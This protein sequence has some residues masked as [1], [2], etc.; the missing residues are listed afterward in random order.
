METIELKAAQRVLGERTADGKLLSAAELVRMAEQKLDQSGLGNLL[1]KIPEQYVWEW[2]DPTVSELRRFVERDVGKYLVNA[3]RD[4][5]MALG[6][7]GPLNDCP[8]IPNWLNRTKKLV[9]IPKEIEEKLLRID[10]ARLEASL[11]FPSLDCM[12]LG[13]ARRDISLIMIWLRSQFPT[14]GVEYLPDDFGS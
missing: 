1:E 14:A 8:P 10:R 3:L 9:A 4:V 12:D 5:G 11:R 7:M 6:F 13:A 2:P